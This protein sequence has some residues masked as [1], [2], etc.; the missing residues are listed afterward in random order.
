MYI[1]RVLRAS[2]RIANHVFDTGTSDHYMQD[3]RVFFNHGG[4]AGGARN[5]SEQAAR[6]FYELRTLHEIVHDL[7]I[8][9]DIAVELGCGYGRLT[10]W[11]SVLTGAEHIIGIDHNNNS[12]AK[13][14]Q[15]YPSDIFKWH[16]SGIAELTDICGQESSDIILSWTV[17][18]HVPSDI[19]DRSA[20][21]IMNT[22]DQG[23]YLILTE[24]TEDDP[25]DHVWGRGIGEYEDLFDALDLVETRDRELEPTYGNYSEGGVVMV[26]EK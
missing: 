19:I 7:R 23:G 3:G 17:L 5:P 1:G 6:N 22:L 20:N 18:Q 10:P 9:A 15:Q 16:T 25:A 4:Q 8:S 13:A 14:E 26:F 11:L 24:E 2:K 12:I 21:E